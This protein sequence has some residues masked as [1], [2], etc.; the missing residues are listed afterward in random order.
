MTWLHLMRARQLCR[1]SFLRATS[2][3]VDVVIVLC[4]HADGIPVHFLVELPRR[5][6]L[7]SRLLFSVGVLG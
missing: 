6:A 5:R 1:P 7:P 3:L 2:Y 4:L